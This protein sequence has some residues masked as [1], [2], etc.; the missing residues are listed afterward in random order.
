MA[1]T[2][3]QSRI[4]QLLQDG[5]EHS[6]EDIH[7]CLWDDQSPI[8]AVN[9]HITQLRTIAHRKGMGIVLRRRGDVTYY[10]LTRYVS[11]S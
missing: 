11:T 4:W 6:R 8:S 1:M 5:Q 7:K 3:V 9:Y 10:A 2:P